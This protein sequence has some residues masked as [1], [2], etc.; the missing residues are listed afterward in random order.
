VSLFRRQCSWPECERGG[1]RSTG[2]CFHHGKWTACYEH[3]YHDIY[4][5][6][7]CPV[8]RWDIPARHYS[9]EA[10]RRNAA[11]RAA[12]EHRL[13]GYVAE[14]RAQGYGQAAAEAMANKRFHEENPPPRRWESD[15]IKRERESAE[16]QRRIDAGEVMRCPVCKQYARVSEGVILGHTFHTGWGENRAIV[17][18]RG[19]GMLA[20]E[21]PA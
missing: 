20:E 3:H 4:S 18:C 15:D 1:G 2:K 21:N 6:D 13:T 16:A 14:F 8:C 9:R 7:L 5:G 19:E 10:E 17:H 12:R 11:E